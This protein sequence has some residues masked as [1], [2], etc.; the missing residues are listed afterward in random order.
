[1]P[2]TPR[3][4]ERDRIL[5]GAVDYACRI[6]RDYL[7]VTARLRDWSAGLGS[8]SGPTPKGTISDPT[9]EAAMSVDEFGR[10]RSR[11]DALVDSMCRDMSAIEQ[12]RREVMAPPP[13][14]EEVE[15]QRSNQ[16][17]GTVQP[18][19]NPHGCPDEG[20]AAK[21]GRCEACY[22]YR[23]RNGRDR[24]VSGKS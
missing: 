10:A 18:C 23:Q 20:L 4:S 14:L 6:G 1:M 15:R 9:G 11:L 2:R 12:I 8:G 13:S 7:M 5:Q 3:P 21:A 16:M 24:R 19:A 17:A 22:K